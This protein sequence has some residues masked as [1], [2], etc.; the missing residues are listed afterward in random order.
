MIINQNKLSG[1]TMKCLFGGLL[2]FFGV[3]TIFFTPMDLFLRERL[4]ML[5]GLPLFVSSSFSID[6]NRYLTG[7]PAFDWW[8]NLEDEIIVSMYVF[9]VT[10][11]DD[12]LSGRDPILRFQEVGPIVYR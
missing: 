12:F 9:N 3:G 11:P 1:P 4:R 5:P 2:L 7:F 6:Q 10:N 8:Y